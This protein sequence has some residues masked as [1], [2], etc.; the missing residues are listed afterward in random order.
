MEALAIAKN[1]V[2]FSVEGAGGNVPLSGMDG[3][4]RFHQGF[5]AALDTG[6]ADDLTIQGVAAR[7][8]FSDQSCGRHA[9]GWPSPVVPHGQW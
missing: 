2:R 6:D 5:L 9:L 4:G 3:L 8:Q 1:F 7:V